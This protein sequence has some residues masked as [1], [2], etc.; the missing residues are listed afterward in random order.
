MADI[1]TRWYK[2]YWGKHEISE[3]KRVTIRKDSVVSTLSE[4]FV[5]MRFHPFSK[6]RTVNMQGA[7]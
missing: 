5:H 4:N 2:G 6:L 3:V 7:R 1:M